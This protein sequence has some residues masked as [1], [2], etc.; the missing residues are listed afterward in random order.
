M[1]KIFLLLM[2]FLS[3]C[4][5]YSFQPGMIPDNIKLVYLSPINNKSSNHVIGD[6]LFDEI[7]S[8]LMNKN[9]IN[10]V[11]HSQ[12]NSRIDLYINSINESPSDFLI[13]NEI[14]IAKQWKMEVRGK[15]EWINLGN[16]QIIQQKDLNVYA[17]YNTEGIDISQDGI[18]ND[19]DG[20]IDSQDTDEYGAPRNTAM[21]IISRKLSDNIIENMLSN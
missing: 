3:S 7:K 10:L 14:A 18:D 12:A 6:L 4:G 17:F 20:L 2:L 19:E 21:I 8:A 1:I 11:N 13:D 9:I 15:M 16:N 5:I